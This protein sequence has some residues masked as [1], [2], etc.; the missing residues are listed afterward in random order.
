MYNAHKNSL[1]VFGLI[2]T[3]STDRCEYNN[4]VQSKEQTD[5]NHTCITYNNLI[6]KHMKFGLNQFAV[7]LR[8]CVC[9]CVCMCLWVCIFRSIFFWPLTSYQATSIIF[10]YYRFILCT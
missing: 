8:V 10:F 7:S 6:Y 4:C 3:L 1:I 2:K 9:L 5:F